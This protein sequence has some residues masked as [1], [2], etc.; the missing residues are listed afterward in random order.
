VKRMDQRLFDRL[1]IA[2]TVA[3]ALYLLF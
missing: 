3:G 2:L 1:V